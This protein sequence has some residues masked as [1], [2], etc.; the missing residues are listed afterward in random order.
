MLLHDL[1]YKF[2]NNIARHNRNGFFCGK[3]GMPFMLYGLMDA[4]SR[5]IHCDV[6]FELICNGKNFNCS[7]L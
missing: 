4:Q 7:I 6:S 1:N 5:W 3:I 2:N